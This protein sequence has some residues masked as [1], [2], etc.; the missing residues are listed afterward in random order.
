[1]RLSY[2]SRRALDIGDQSSRSADSG[3]YGRSL[4]ETFGHLSQVKRPLPLLECRR[5]ANHILAPPATAWCSW[6]Y[7]AAASAVNKLT[8]PRITASLT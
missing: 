3:L 2:R 5:S 6:F 4:R 8:D 1:M 7:A